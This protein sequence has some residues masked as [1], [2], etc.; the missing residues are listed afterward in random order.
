MPTPQ[1]ERQEEPFAKFPIGND[2]E[3]ARVMCCRLRH[4]PQKAQETTET[5]KSTKRVS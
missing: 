3:A 1:K 2:I 4:S 5:T